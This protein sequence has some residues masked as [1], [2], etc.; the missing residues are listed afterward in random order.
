MKLK[1]L[2]ASICLM[3]TAQM[4]QATLV[5]FYGTGGAATTKESAFKSALSPNTRAV[6]SLE[7]PNGARGWGGS[8][9][10]SPPPVGQTPL[11]LEFDSVSSPGTITAGGIAGTSQITRVAGNGRAPHTGDYFFEGQDFEITFASA[12]SAFGFWGSDIGDFDCP[13]GA[14]GCSAAARGLTVTLLDKDGNSLTAS[15]ISIDGSTLG[16]ELFWGVVDTGGA[17]IAKVVFHNRTGGLDAQGFDDFMIGAVDP[18]FDPRDPNGTP[19]PGVLAL[20]GL[21]LAG[22][23]RARR[24]R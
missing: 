20:V 15:P 19:E 12:V 17:N 2:A 9:F 4:A 1:A 21:A 8:D 10:A 22:A 23:A 24:R 13:V 11:G 5:D 7:D 18:N 16:G 3:A 14:T 6:D